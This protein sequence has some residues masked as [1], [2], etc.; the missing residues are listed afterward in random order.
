MA[1]AYRDSSGFLRAPATELVYNQKLTLELK[2]TH[3]H[4]TKTFMK[5]G[6]RS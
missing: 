6:A 4:S 2:D 5:S 1:Q 3:C